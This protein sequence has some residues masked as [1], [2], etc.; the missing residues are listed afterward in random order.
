MK[1]FT[2]NSHLVQAERRRRLQRDH[3][4]RSGE[5][6]AKRT[7]GSML[8]RLGVRLAGLEEAW[9]QLALRH[10]ELRSRAEPPLA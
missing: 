1:D 3:R 8:I 10:R 5:L 6:R 9:S 7:V 2:S 4:P